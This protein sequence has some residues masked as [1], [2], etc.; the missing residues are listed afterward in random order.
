M[1]DANSDQVF[2]VLWDWCVLQVQSRKKARTY[3]QDLVRTLYRLACCENHVKD[4]LKCSLLEH[5]SYVQATLS[6]ACFQ[7]LS[8]FGRQRCRRATETLQSYVVA[9]L[10][11]PALSTRTLCCEMIQR[12]ANLGYLSETLLCTLDPFVVRLL[13]KCRPQPETIEVVMRYLLYRKHDLTARP[14]VSTFLPCGGLA[15]KKAMEYLAI[16]TAPSELDVKKVLPVSSHYELGQLVCMWP[17]DV[18]R[19]YLSILETNDTK[20]LEGVELLD[21]VEMLNYCRKVRDELHCVVPMILQSLK[22]LNHTTS[23]EFRVRLWDT[24]WRV[25]GKVHS[26]ELA[27]YFPD[28]LSLVNRLPHLSFYWSKDRI[29]D[30]FHGIYEV[31]PLLF[32]NMNYLDS[33]ILEILPD[34]MLRVYMDR[35]VAYLQQHM[36]AFFL[37]TEIECLKFICRMTFVELKK[38]K[39]FVTKHK[40]VLVQCVS[41]EQDDARLRLISR[42][43]LYKLPDELFDACVPVLETLIGNGDVSG[44]LTMYNLSCCRLRVL[45][46]AILDRVLVQRDIFSDHLH[47]SPA[48]SL[49]SR[50]PDDVL[51]TV[52]ERLVDPCTQGTTSSLPLFELE[53]EDRLFVLKNLPPY[54]LSHL[55]VHTLATRYF[56]DDASTTPARFRLMM[57]IITGTNNADVCETYKERALLSSGGAG[58]YHQ[59]DTYMHHLAD[60]MLLCLHPSSLASFLQELGILRELCVRRACRLL[61]HL[62][63]ASLSMFTPD[64]LFFCETNPDV[65]V[66]VEILGRLPWDELWKYK[67]RIMSLYEESSRKPHGYRHIL[68]IFSNAGVRLARELLLEHGY[69]YVLSN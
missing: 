13:E 68:N 43:L 45:R 4:L 15:W 22:R 41:A 17:Y 61:D 65:N 38:H 50:L 44:L 35:I 14:C 8:T 51:T 57:E 23:S 48:L 55:H 49:M 10:D 46:H 59:D 25:L 9:L 53:V 24:S 60:K 52:V 21:A 19:F 1:S 33:C 3:R 66:C 28:L 39:A 31:E 62:D 20:H 64:I 16:S 26:G 56:M 12:L 58:E 30:I 32:A 29:K 37:P 67:D 54:L 11:H 40:K 36:C 47:P 69:E 7:L 18:Q 34:N 63:N 42:Q 6:W 5:D 2:C 27:K